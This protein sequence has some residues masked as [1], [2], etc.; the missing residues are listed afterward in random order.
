MRLIKIANQNEKVFFVDLDVGEFFI[1]QG[2]LF[3]KTYQSK[4]GEKVVFNSFA[5][6]GE[7]NSEFYC[8]KQARVQPVKLVEITY[9]LG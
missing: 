3:R 8:D 7:G 4:T 9:Y 6:S 2:E 1:F 5:V